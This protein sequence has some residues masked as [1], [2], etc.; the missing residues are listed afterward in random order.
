MTVE[1]G[2]P[3]LYGSW[4]AKLGPDPLREDAD[5]EVCDAVM[6]ISICYTALLCRSIVACRRVVCSAC[7]NCVGLS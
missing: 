1:H 6:C 4:A 5:K 7:A 3:E 2:G